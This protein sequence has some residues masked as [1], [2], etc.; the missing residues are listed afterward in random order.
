MTHGELYELLSGGDR[1]SIADSNRARRL[2][3][4]DPT[5]V[6]QLAAL[7]GDENWLIVQ[8]VLDLLQKLAHDH[9]EWIEPHTKVFIGPLVANDKGE[10]RLQSLRAQPRF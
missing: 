7:A 5:R 9:A 4:C 1:R 8:R 2:I 10:T 3:E 6:G